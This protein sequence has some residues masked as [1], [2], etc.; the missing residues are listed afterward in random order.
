[1]QGLY[2]RLQTNKCSLPS[3]ELWPQTDSNPTAKLFHVFHL[4]AS[5]L[6]QESKQ[7]F[8]LRAAEMIMGTVAREIL[9]YII[10]E[11]AE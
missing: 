4:R 2:L 3:A 9:Y 1:M 5:R 6:N 10:Y 7:L 8:M 11:K